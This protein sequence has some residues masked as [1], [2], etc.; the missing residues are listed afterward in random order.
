MQSQTDDHYIWIDN[1]VKLRT[2]TTGAALTKDLFKDFIVFCNDNGIATIPP[3]QVF[4]LVLSYFKGYQR[5]RTQAGTLISL[6]LK[7]I[8][9]K[10][11]GSGRNGIRLRIR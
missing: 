4:G 1:W 10:S 2:V 6:S 5:R 7:P 3:I 8:D 11:A 9:Q